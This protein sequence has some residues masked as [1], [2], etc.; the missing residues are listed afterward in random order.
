MKLRVGEKGD[1]IRDLQNSL[2]MLGYNPG[3]VNGIFSESTK[4]AIIRLQ[5]DKNFQDDGM[6]GPNTLKAL[7]IKAGLH[8][9]RPARKT[10]RGLN[11]K[12]KG[13]IHRR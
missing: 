6:V 2:L 10:R 8:I 12:N 4:K 13:N 1:L 9:P 11:S 3:P 7:G 5:K